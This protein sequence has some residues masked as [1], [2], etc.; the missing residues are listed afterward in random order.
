MG[1]D[2]HTIYK[3]YIEDQNKVIQVKDLQICKDITF[4]ATM[5][6]SDFDRKSNFN[7]IQIPNKQIPS[8]KSNISKK[9]KN[10]QK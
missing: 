9:E 4:K 6:L 3:V 10:P 5:F 2:G 1:F 8:N 7:K